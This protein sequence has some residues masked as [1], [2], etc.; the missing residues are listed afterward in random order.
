MDGLRIFKYKENEVRM[1]SINDEPWW[2]LKDVCNVLGIKNVTDTQNRLDEDEIS[3]L[4]LI[5]V[6]SNG[7]QQTRK[8]LIVNESGLYAVILRSD[9]PEAKKFRKWI[10][11]EVLPTIR[12]TGG[13]VHNDEL[14]V[15][16][17]LAHVDEETKD[18][19]RS[20]LKAIRVLDEKVDTLEIALNESIKF[21]TVAKYNKIFN[22]GWPLKTCQE[23]GKGLSVYCRSRAIEIRKCKTNDERFGEV[24]SYPLTAWEDFFVSIGGRPS[25][26]LVN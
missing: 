24:N 18:I 13:Y 1:V 15:S 16:T 5:E 4:G 14:F 19:F 25:A 12:K 21:Y 9:K 10:T 17:Y 7:V 26:D 2:V 23:I 11:N 8:R 6:S 3:E 20:S 22:M